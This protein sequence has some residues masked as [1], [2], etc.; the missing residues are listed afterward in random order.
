M[1]IRVEDWARLKELFLTMVETDP[2]SRTRL[3]DQSGASPELRSS[4]E[5]LLKAHAQA[6]SLLH[7]SAAFAE[8]FP[9]ESSPNRL[10]AGAVLLDRFQVVRFIARGGMGEVYEA[11]D[12]ELQTHVA[13]KTIR[14][15]IAASPAALARFRR[16]V[17]L[18][19]RVTHPGVCRV[20]DLFRHRTSSDASG[21]VVFVSMELLH[22]RTLAER[23]QESGR[24][25][26]EEIL[27]ILRQIIPALETAHAAGVLH[28]DLKPANLILE[29]NRESETRAVITDFGLA[30][31]QDSLPEASP[32]G[33][34]QF[35]FGTPEYMPPEQIEGR[36]PT[37]ASDLY[38]L[39]L[40]I[41]QML[42]GTRAFESDGPLLSALR[43][44]KECPPPP[45]R[46]VP[47]LGVRWDG[48]LS[49]CLDPDPGRRFCS[50]RQL[51]DAVESAA[52][53][54][55]ERTRTL[56]F[57]PA[58]PSRLPRRWELAAVALSVG[59]VLTGAALFFPYPRRRFSH[60]DSLT[61]VLSDFVNA[62]GDP[63]FD[64]S[65][66]VALE[67]KLQQSPFISLM[68]QAR[69]RRALSY[70]GLSGS[71]RLTRELGRQVCRREDGQVVLQGTILSRGTGY[72]LWLRSFDCQ[73]GK[74]IA[75]DERSVAGRDATL[76]A[77][78]QLADSMR[79]QLGESSE[80]LH[81]F[82]V[83]L[84]DASTSSITAL[85]AYARGLQISD[86]QGEF[87]AAP[88]FQR[89]VQLDP[90]FAIAYARL[91]S[92]YWDRGQLNHARQAALQA[93]IRRDRVTAWER[94]FILAFY[95]AFATGELDKEVHTYEAWGHAY[96]HGTDWP[97]GL[98]VDYSYYGEYAGAGKM[99]RRE[100][101]NDPD[102]AVAYGDL[103]LD[104]LNRDRPDEARA[105]LNQADAEHLHEINMDWDRYWLAFY[106]ND[107]AGMNQVVAH[108][109]AYPGLQE[110]LMM[111]QARTE[112]WY[113]H[114]RLSRQ[115][116]D[117]AFAEAS[118]TDGADVVALDRAKEAFWEAEFGNKAEARADVAR[119][120]TSSE[121]SRNSDLHVV[122]ALDF[123]V[124]GETDKAQAIVAAFRKTWPLRTMLNQYWI[125]V[126]NAEIALHEG[127]PQVAGQLLG[128]ATPFDTGIFDPLPCCMYSV[129]VR[130]QTH[131]A[132][133][134]GAAAASDFREILVHRGVV[135]NC[136]TGAL[137]QLGLARALALSGDIDDSRTEYQ[138]VLAL[139]KSAD[140]G[141]GVVREARMEYRALQ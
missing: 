86:E 102:S 23:I 108:A 93:Y 139:W 48:L 71:E 141:L 9:A 16:E 111:Q 65:L 137:A 97:M 87:A 13:I 134:Q 133:R 43:R 116:A 98:A 62:T 100:I 1:D 107:P 24:M 21:D 33:T 7:R 68:S 127:Q 38:S 78:D 17:H 79:A 14:P 36:R 136:P 89:A 42:T 74:R 66:N 35:T 27:L 130:G 118:R 40:V 121:H 12:K 140:P 49:R 28:R 58:G 31:S 92:I 47:Q 129:Y 109:A 77:L 20:F 60:E 55:A 88:Y 123:A 67:A 53:S 10:T 131:L 2:S 73:T 83:P 128:A 76:T 82:N 54:A 110:T 112:A 103:A 96:P 132:M 51:L 59:A 6:G 25:S 8:N 72:D 125:P 32:P 34:G 122:E 80:S 104:Y 94:Y 84:R 114:L 117:K 70:M 50:A 37:P 64:R 105:I 4:V 44:L 26:P 61:I 18:A 106:T 57:L 135:L 19:R 126:V 99:L 22:G 29:I 90:N 39:G 119:A 81:R 138:N 15:E 3:L 75:A 101:S 56:R 120:V 113:G 52:D 11:L 5:E 124:L 30:W 69:V 91:A 63:A 45:S 85:T 115:F 95:Y 41:Y 46:V